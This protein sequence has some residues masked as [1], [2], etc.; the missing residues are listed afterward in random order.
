MC[1]D[2][3]LYQR[4]GLKS[5]AGKSARIAGN[6]EFL[7]ELPLASRGESLHDRERRTIAINVAAMTA[8]QRGIPAVSLGQHADA[9]SFDH[10][11]QVA[12]QADEACR[13][14]NRF[15]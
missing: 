2:L 15:L 6:Q 8:Q 5:M 13:G 11:A 9:F 7:V 3:S 4:T 14:A 10:A 1:I 12:E